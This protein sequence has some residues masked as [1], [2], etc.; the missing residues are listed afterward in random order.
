MKL[1]I[2]LFFLWSNGNDGRPNRSPSW[3]S[4]WTSKEKFLCMESK[5]LSTKDLAGEILI[6]ILKCRSYPREC[7][8][9]WI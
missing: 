1:T 5:E 7:Y 9:I 3:R 6:L 2:F 4:L 8:I